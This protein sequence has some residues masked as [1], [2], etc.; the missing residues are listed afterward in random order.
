MTKE[1]LG[2]FRAFEIARSLHSGGVSAESA[3][4][5]RPV[6]EGGTVGDG[7]EPSRYRVH[8]PAISPGC[9]IPDHNTI[10]QLLSYDLR[11]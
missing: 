6:A 7:R 4:R 3:G 2:G 5:L 10:P 1:T 9:T 11:N 8:P